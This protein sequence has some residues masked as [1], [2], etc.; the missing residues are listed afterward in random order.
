MSFNILII[1]VLFYS[2]CILEFLIMRACII[3]YNMIIN[4]SVTE[5][6]SQTFLKKRT[7][8]GPRTAI[9]FDFACAFFHGLL[10][11]SFARCNNENCT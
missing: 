11:F 10:D 1:L 4:E 3:L 9:T 8:L 2:R 6:Y 7:I 5:N